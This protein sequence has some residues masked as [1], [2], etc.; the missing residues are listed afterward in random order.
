[1]TAQWFNP[2]GSGAS[3]HDNAS[4]HGLA[5]DEVIAIYDDVPKANSKKKK[6][7]TVKSTVELWIIRKAAAEDGREKSWKR[8]SK[9]RLNSSSDDLIKNLEKK[10]RSYIDTFLSLESL[11]QRQVNVLV[12]DRQ[13]EE[14]HPDAEWTPVHIHVDLGGKSKGPKGKARAIWV[15]LERRSKKSSNASSPSSKHAMNPQRGDIVDLEDRMNRVRVR[16][17]YLKTEHMNEMKSESTRHRDMPMAVDH[18]PPLGSQPQ[19]PA[20]MQPWPPQEIFQNQQPMCPPQPVP[21]V[22]QPNAFSSVQASAQAPVVDVHTAGLPVD[23]TFVRTQP[24]QDEPWPSFTPFDRAEEPPI[25][26]DQVR[27]S[28]HDHSPPFRNDQTKTHTH[29]PMLGKNDHHVEMQVPRSDG[30]QH[31]LIDRHPRVD[32]AEREREK[33][34]QVRRPSTPNTE[35][36]DGFWSSAGHPSTAPSSVSQGSHG[37][38]S[39]DNF[40]TYD[41]APRERYDDRAPC[42]YGP[43]GRRYYDHSGSAHA[44]VEPARTSAQRP[45]VFNDRQQ[46]QYRDNHETEIHQEHSR[47]PSPPSRQ[48]HDG[49]QKESLPFRSSEQRPGYTRRRTNGSPPRRVYAERAEFDRRQSDEPHKSRDHAFHVDD[50]YVD[51][52]REREPAYQSQRYSGRQEQRPNYDRHHSS[53]LTPPR[54]ETGDQLH[55]VHAPRAYSPFTSHSS[56]GPTTH[57]S[58]PASAVVIENLSALTRQIAELKDE[59]QRQRE[60]EEQK[61]KDEEAREMFERAREQG[62]EE[63][64]SELLTQQARDRRVPPWEKRM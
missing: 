63:A 13:D 46:Y 50:Y 62:R 22:P 1:M 51:R 31:P 34:R 49:D 64:R 4:G 12:E 56:S 32:W 39:F 54:R 18:G 40:P 59:R 53:P 60:E 15:Y 28:Q 8:I 11:Q 33:L 52:V 44:I 17:K 55:H 9:E 23:N 25:N 16:D 7:E 26:H 14:D 10:G 57:L 38:A 29:E 30:A 36:S 42:R 41:H 43:S 5:S 6:N 20:M 61:R 2:S 27:P 19:F 24:T 48:Y 47:R 58:D 45:H 21:Q 37:R 35:E 3:Y